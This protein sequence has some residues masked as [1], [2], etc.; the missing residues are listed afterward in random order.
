MLEELENNILP[1]WMT[2]MEDKAAGGFIG[3][4][5]GTGEPDPAAPKGAILNARILWTFSAAWRLFGKCEYLET[6]DRSDRFA[7]SLPVI[8]FHRIG[9]IG[10][11]PVLRIHSLVCIDQRLVDM[12]RI[13]D[14]LHFQRRKSSKSA[15]CAKQ[16]GYDDRDIGINGTDLFRRFFL[17]IPVTDDS[18]TSLPGLV[19]QI[20]RPDI[21][22]SVKTPSN[23]T[24]DFQKL[25]PVFRF[26]KN[27]LSFRSVSSGQLVKID[28]HFDSIFAAEF[29]KFLKRLK[30]VLQIFEILRI[31]GAKRCN[32]VTN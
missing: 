17:Q 29:Q 25:I 3:R 12:N 15:R 5:S 24:P 4:I 9:K 23:P 1:F 18:P 31:S 16:R 28:Y 10:N 14:I 8:S 32:L 26:E 21:R 13:K 20:V 2:R 6:A 11:R 30:I 22:I 19:H 7:E 27:F